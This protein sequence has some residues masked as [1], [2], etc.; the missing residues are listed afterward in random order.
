M[1]G[2]VLP[3]G[4][5]IKET[6]E[7]ALAKKNGTSLWEHA[8]GTLI[9]C[10]HLIKST[11]NYD[12]L[13]AWHLR[14]A[15]LLHDI[16][17]MEPA[18]Q[19]FLKDDSLKTIK[20]EKYS[21]NYYDWILESHQA[22]SE[23]I[24]AVCGADDIKDK[25]QDEDKKK[26]DENE[27]DEEEDGSEETK[28]VRLDK[29]EIAKTN[30]T[31]E[32]DLWGLIVSHHGVYYL[33]FEKNQFKTSRDWTKINT[34]GEITITLA[35]LLWRYYPLGGAV[36]FADLLHS[37]WL[38][39]DKLWEE[40]EQLNSIADIKDKIGEHRLQIIENEGTDRKQIVGVD[41]MK[42]LLMR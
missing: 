24:T 31:N 19:S 5:P 15:S 39:G 17:K 16:G 22:I 18:F 36:I 34:T 27:N 20:H 30:Q 33:V 23:I 14:V 29:N 11:P 13:K 32:I 25:S 40:I 9:I 12:P 37:A 38:N 7:R 10:N 6:F 26:S 21:L 1:R 8:V 3:D 42:I 4:N 35:D 41:V 28:T 2:V